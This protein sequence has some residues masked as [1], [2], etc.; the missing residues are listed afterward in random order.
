VTASPAKELMRAIRRP[1]VLSAISLAFLAIHHGLLRAMA[2]DH[3]AHVLL[4]AGNA[5]TDPKAAALA[6][7][8]LAVRFV[9]Y[10]LVPGL[11]LAA[12]AEIVA[13]L[14]VGPKRTNDE[15]ELA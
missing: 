13:Y 4:G 1:L 3:V 15:D 6:V 7:S 2:H 14:L 12:A 5:P 8:L 10:I 9:S 11:L